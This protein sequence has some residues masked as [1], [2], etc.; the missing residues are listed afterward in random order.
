[1]LA[2]AKISKAGLVVVPWT[3]KVALGVEELM[4]RLPEGVKLMMVAPVEV[5]KLKTL[6][7]PAMPWMVKAT[8]VEVAPTPATVPLSISLPLP[9]AE[10]EVQMATWPTA[11]PERAACLLLKV[12]QSVEVRQPETEAEELGQLITKDIPVPKVEVEMLKILPAVPV[13]TLLSTLVGWLITKE[14]VEVEI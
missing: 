9:M 10:A 12:D 11:P 1:M 6:L 13:E 3:T 7:A 5:L 2:T 14:L 8:L 4:A